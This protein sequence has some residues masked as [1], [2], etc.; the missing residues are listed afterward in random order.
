M[1]RIL[2]PL[3]VLGVGCGSTGPGEETAPSNFAPG[4]AFDDSR[5]KLVVFGGQEDNS[6][7][8]AETWEWDGSGWSQS[9]V[10]GPSGRMWAAMAYDSD[11]RKVVLFGGA[12]SNGALGDTWEYDGTQWQQFQ[13]PGPQPRFAHEMAY[14]TAAHRIVLFGGTASVPL[15]DVWTWD[16]AQWTAV[17][18]SGPAPTPRFAHAFAYDLARQHMVAFGGHGPAVGPTMQ[19]LGDGWLRIGS[20]WNAAPPGPAPSPR[21][22]VSMAYDEERRVMVLHG[23]V[24]SVGPQE[25]RDTW[26]FDGAVWTA[27]ATGGPQ[28]RG[29]HRLVYDRT[30]RRVILLTGAATGNS[31]E[32]WTWNGTR[33]S[34]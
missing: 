19:S 16:G 1:T 32:I 9:P 13:V 3:L 10:S 15:A 2:L 29:N 33:W 31:V 6:F 27:K 26:E 4:I 8:S 7:L 21:D 18:G 12:G 22:H 24:Y 5:G 34:R 25:L 14:D 23:G 11:R 30:R 20:Q 17:P 28:A